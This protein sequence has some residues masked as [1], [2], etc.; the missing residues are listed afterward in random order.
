MRIN[1]KKFGVFIHFLFNPLLLSL[2]NSHFNLFFHGKFF[3]TYC[4]V[5]FKMGL[6]FPEK[7]KHG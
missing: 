7:E 3:Q 2:K 6:F 1:K 5:N 4:K